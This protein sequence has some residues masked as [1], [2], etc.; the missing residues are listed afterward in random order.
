MS[1]EYT[2]NEVREQFLDHVRMMIDYWNNDSI[3]TDTKEKLSGLAHSILA[4]IDG[5]NM[6]LP[7]FILAPCPCEGDKQYYI[8]KGENYYTENKN[9][10]CDIAGGLHELLYT[11]NI[12]LERRKKLKKIDKI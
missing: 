7:G 3:T 9:V 6:D 12:K 1:R 5:C 4:T 8:D 11:K 2:E 10:N